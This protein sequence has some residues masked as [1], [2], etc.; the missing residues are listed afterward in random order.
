MTPPDAPPNPPAFPV[1][2]I[3]TGDP[4]D[5]MTSGSDGIS[6]RQYLY[7]KII[8]GFCAN[9]SVFAPNGMSG[10]ALVNCSPEDLFGYAHFL[11]EKAMDAEK[12]AMLAERQRREGR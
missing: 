10:W 2:S 8:Q 11:A 4:R 1:P 5:G 12:A 3:G 7:A 6:Y 9:P